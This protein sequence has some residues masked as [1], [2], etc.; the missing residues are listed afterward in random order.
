MKIQD[1]LTALGYYSYKWAEV[2][3]ADAFSVFEKNGIFDKQT[4]ND[5]E[6]LILAC[7]GA[8]D[9]LVNIEKFLGRKPSVDSL[10]KQSGIEQ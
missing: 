4:A 8:Y 2:L 6:D 3:A 1:S 10:L 7:G 5:F 9:P